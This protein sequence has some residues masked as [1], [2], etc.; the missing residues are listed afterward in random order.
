MARWGQA[1]CG[2]AGLVW[3]VEVRT[4]VVCHGAACWGRR[5]KERSGRSGFDGARQVRRGGI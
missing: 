4:G 1:S 3:Y 5:G 2:K